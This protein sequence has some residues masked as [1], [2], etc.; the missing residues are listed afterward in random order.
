MN[1]IALIEKWGEYLLYN[2][3]RSEATANT[4]RLHLVRL[5]AYLEQHGQTLFSTTPSILETYCGRFLHSQNLRPISRRVPIVAI[6]GFFAWSY[7][8]QLLDAN[9]AATL[10]M[11]KIANKLARAMSLSDAERLLMAP[12]IEDFAGLRDTAILAVLIASGC[13]VSGLVNLTDQ[14][15]IWTQ[16]QNS[17]E[18]L[19]I[20]LSEKGKKE[21][22]VPVPLEAALLVRAYL[23]SPDLARIDRTL[24]NGKSILFVNRRNRHCERHDHY[25]QRRQLSRDAVFDLVRKHGRQAGIAAEYLHPHALRHLYGV[26]LAESDVDLLVRKALLGHARTETVEV[27]SHLAYRKIAQ[28]A[29]QANPI[30][31]MSNT[32]ARALA[33]RLQAIPKRQNPRSEG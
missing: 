1:E 29:E 33:S 20:R 6:R 28:A 3:G 13:R 15:L 5:K 18:R 19:I 2:L 17:T 25:G 10:P 8:H 32:P 23:G 4:Y 7:Q 16:N 14:D 31:K 22:L 30:T 9:P 26:E 21:R 11:P 24:P 12:G 27:Y